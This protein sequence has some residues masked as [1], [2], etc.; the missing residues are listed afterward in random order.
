MEEKM[1]LNTLFHYSTMLLLTSVSIK[2]MEKD[3]LDLSASHEKGQQIGEYYFS[4]HA[5]DRMQQ[6]NINQQA[7]EAALRKGDRHWCKSSTRQL[8]IDSGSRLIVVLQARYGRDGIKK[9][10]ATKRPDKVITVFRAPSREK[11]DKAILCGKKEMNALKAL[12]IDTNKPG[13]LKGNYFY[14]NEALKRMHTRR[15]TPETV[16][17][18]AKHGDRYNTFGGA[19]LCIDIQ[20][21]IAVLVERD[22]KNIV[23]V[24]K[25]I[26]KEKLDNWII[27][28]DIA[29]N[30][31]RKDVI[32][33]TEN[34]AHNNINYG[35]N[36]KENLDFIAIDE[37]DDA[38]DYPYDTE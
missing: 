17:W 12:T 21:K 3:S 7:V 4:G 16:S 33:I 35:K 34:K 28:R 36:K 32:K 1:K 5:L 23:S 26:T 14:Y 37:D 24:F 10:F 22:T 8:C 18:V 19:Q 27:E 2:G 30:Q 15:L 29:I 6:R 38:Y 13:E 9:E 25:G 31:Y 11:I 20:S